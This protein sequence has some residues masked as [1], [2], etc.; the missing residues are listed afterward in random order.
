M[1]KELSMRSTRLFTIATLLGLACCAAGRGVETQPPAGASPEQRGYWLLV[2]KPYVTPDF[3]QETF[4]AVWKVWPEPLKSQA[5]KATPEQRRKMAFARYGLT[6]RPEDPTRPLQYVVDSAGVWT[7]NCFAC[8]GGQVAGKIWPG[9]PNS[10][11][12]LQT[13]T[14]ET[15]AVKVAQGKPLGRM[16]FGSVF[17]PLGSTN[18]TTNAVN[19]GVALMGFRDADLNFHADRLPPKMT[20]HDLDAP[21]WWHFRRKQMLYI[22]GFAEKGHR[23]LSQFAMVRSNGPEKFRQ[24]EDEFRDVFAYISSLEPPSYPYSI[25]RALADRG[26]IAFE[27]NCADCHGTYGPDGKYPEKL[28]AIDEVQTDRV[29]LDALTP[30]NRDAYGQ[31]WF[32]DY[33]K[34]K[35]VRDP[36]LRR[37]AAGRRMG[38][39]LRTCTTAASHAVARAAP[40]RAPAVWKRTIDGYDP[41][42]VGL[43]I[44]ALAEIPAEVK[45]GWERRTYFDTRGFG[46]SRAGHDFPDALSEDEKQAVLVPQD[47]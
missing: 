29:R 46:K 30:T 17:V 20:H 31:S 25:D 1:R 28:V 39:P 10:H 21:P 14:E 2:N 6:P 18:G 19:F 36:G 15:R 8:H 12:A 24:W 5:E 45:S 3:D 16:D 40:Q 9:L 13:L 44:A 23:A 35:Y 32:A 38:Q 22:D 37:S 26:R 4:D 34:K 27:K 43:E 47:A 33:G 42:R 7:M 11:Y 41:K